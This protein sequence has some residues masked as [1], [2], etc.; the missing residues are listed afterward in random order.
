LRVRIFGA[1]S[2][3]DYGA[4]F[5]DPA[6]ARWNSVDP[7]AE[8][9]SS[10]SS[11]NYVLNNPIRFIDPDGMQVDDII[12]PKEEDRGEILKN[13]QALTNDKLGINPETGEVFVAKSNAANFT[14]K[15]DEGTS[16]VKDLINDDNTVSLHKTKVGNGT[17][18]VDT[19]G[20]IIENPQQ[21]VES[22]SSVGVTLNR[23]STI[24]EDGSKGGQP[25]FITL[26]HEL[27]HARELA[28]GT[29]NFKGINVAFD[30]DAKKAT[31]KFTVRELNTRKFENKLRSE[32]GLKRRALPVIL[33]K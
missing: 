4:R 17:N 18:S 29:T 16:L 9:Y 33:F 14:K 26:G 2:W 30:F 13:L 19:N 12:I 23:T 21:G 5:Y 27:Q 7:L 3:L 32:H 11:Y 31:G 28:L 1:G 24:N 15:L 10:Q 25:G 8:K 6:I 20:N 22:D